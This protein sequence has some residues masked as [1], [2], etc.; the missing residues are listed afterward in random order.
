MYFSSSTDRICTWIQCGVK[1]DGGMK[2]DSEVF[3]LSTRR[4]GFHVPGEERSGE[5]F[6]LE[7]VMR[8]LLRSVSQQFFPPFLFFCFF[9]FKKKK[10]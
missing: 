5:K 2:N 7:Y 9:L 6:A 4:A 8:L 1:R 10:L 3:N